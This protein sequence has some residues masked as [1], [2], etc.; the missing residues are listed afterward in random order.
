VRVWLSPRKLVRL[1]GAALSATLVTS[2]A[3]AAVGLP[4]Q[5]SV[6]AEA[7]TQQDVAEQARASEPQREQLTAPFAS[8]SPSPVPAPT[9]PPGVAPL[10]ALHAA[11]L[12]VTAPAPL[13]P[14][15]VTALQTLDEVTGVAL[16]DTGSVQIGGQDTRLVGVDPGQF[17]QFTPLQTAESDALWDVVARG[18]LTVSHALAAERGLELGADVEVAAAT[19]VPQRLGALASYGLP[20]IEAVTDRAGARELGAVPDSG[21]LVS[22]PDKK[23]PALRKAVE[24]VVAKTAAVTVLR[25]EKPKAVGVEGKPKNYRELYIDSARYCPGLDWRI[26]AAIGQVES[27]HG[28]NLGPSSAGALGPMQFMPATWAAYGLDGDGDGAADIMNPFDAV[29]SAASYLCRSGATRG[30][31]GLYNAIFAYNH[32][33]WYVRKVL[34]LA[35]QYS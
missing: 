11:D 2:T 24:Q 12:L 29:P 26:L 25:P 6:P 23:M 14:D 9:E 33:D 35:P 18:E 1:V 28:K 17:R 30:E 4:G 22:A 32:A 34:A 19:A 21:V 31:Q 20:E 15:Q 8:S 16:L 7:A 13:T 3:I 27:G 10:Q 5:R